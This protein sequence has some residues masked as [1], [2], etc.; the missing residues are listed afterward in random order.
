MS[1][2][3]RT[4]VRNHDGRTGVTVRDTFAVCDEQDVLVVYE[5][6]THGEATAV[7]ELTTLGPEQAQAEFKAC[8]AGLG[9]QCCIFLTVGREG[10]CCERYSLLRDTIRMRAHTMNAQREPTALYPNCQLEVKNG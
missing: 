8:G 3:L 6:D 4:L 9:D 10:P 2:P 5:G 1:I 7:A